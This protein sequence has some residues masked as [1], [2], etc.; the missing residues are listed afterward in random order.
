M[1]AKEGLA[2]CRAPLAFSLAARLGAQKS[3]VSTHPQLAAN[4]CL[5]IHIK[6]GKLPLL[7]QASRSASSSTAS[8]V[9]E[10]ESMVIVMMAMKRNR[11][12]RLVKSLTRRARREKK[13]TR[14]RGRRRRNRGEFSTLDEPDDDDDVPG[15]TVILRGG[16]GY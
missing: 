11:L 3:R 10:E 8:L 16:K 4:A 5:G 13:G 9:I 15:V 14:R 12:M 1:V 6:S 7:Y 2:G